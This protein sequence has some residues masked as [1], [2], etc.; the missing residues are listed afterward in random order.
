MN[1]KMHGESHTRLHNIWLDMR[2]RCENP[3]RQA[4]SRYGGR[5]IKV[6]DE[7]QDYL[8]FAE[9]ARSNGYADNLTIERNDVNGIYCPKNCTWVPLEAQARNRRPTFWVTFDG[10]KMSLAEACELAGLPYKQVHHR[11]SRLGWSIDRALSTPMQ[12]GC[13]LR[14]KCEK[15]GM[16]YG[17]VV[18]RIYQLGWSEERALNTPT[19]G[20]GANQSSY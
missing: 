9:W 4:Y 13:L 10:R 19:L 16:N 18:T 6:C 1:S 5:G 15:L 3:S 14:E 17:T 2:R 12:R 11:I 20:K 8:C 7:W